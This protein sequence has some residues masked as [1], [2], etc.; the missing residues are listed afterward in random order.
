LIVDRKA[1]VRKPTFGVI[2]SVSALLLYFT[3]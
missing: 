2:V 3:C 1:I